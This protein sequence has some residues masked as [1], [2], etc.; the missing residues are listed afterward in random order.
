MNTVEF[1]A[2]G[3]KVSSPVKLPLNLPQQGEAIQS[4]NLAFNFS[5]TPCSQSLEF[6]A[7]VLT[8]HG[9]SICLSSDIPLSQDR[10]AVDRH[11]RFTVDQQFSFSWDNNTDL[12]QVDSANVPDLQLLTFWLLHSILP[13]YLILRHS[14]F[15]LHASVANID[16]E[17]VIFVA[18]SLGG[19]ST[20]ADHVVRSGFNFL[21]DDKVRL[22]SSS[23][24]Y[25]ALPSHPYRRPSRELEALGEYTENF[26]RHS[27][28]INSIFS[29]KLVDSLQPVR[30]S[31]VLGLRKFELLK[32]ACLYAPA[33]L[34]AVQIRNVLELS[35][36]CTVHSVEVPSSITRLPEA[37][38]AILNVV[39]NKQNS[40]AQQI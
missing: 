11:W 40:H 30:A 37:L 2:Y 10:R 31:E 22:L 18:P 32:D 25:R 3:V 33:S 5:A 24:R 20:M 38:E 6:Q 19:K 34:S 15:F 7:P 28:P 9:R 26:T 36:Q 12:I 21:S 1:I 27:L 23:N 39:R 14:S 16:E 8:M 35:Q 4:V 17:A 13:I 29:L